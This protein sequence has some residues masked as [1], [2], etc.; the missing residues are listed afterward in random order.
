MQ[1][2]SLYT[3]LAKRLKL[4]HGNAEISIFIL[5][6]CSI[7][8]QLLH[9]VFCNLCYKFVY[10]IGQCL[11]FSNHFVSNVEQCSEISK[12]NVVFLLSFM[13]NVT[14]Q[15]KVLDLHCCNIGKQAKKL[16]D[17]LNSNDV[18]EQLWLRGNAL[19]VM[20]VLF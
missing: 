20:K 8:I 6:Q 3:K 16:A 17:A 11:K 10:A 5:H 1:C 4:L 15:L 18:L 9:I 2:K 14:K 12:F 19:C 7:F 13:C